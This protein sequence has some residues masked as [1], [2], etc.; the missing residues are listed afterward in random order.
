GNTPRTVVESVKGTANEVS[1]RYT[2]IKAGETIEIQCQT[3]GA[4]EGATDNLF[5]T[6]KFYTSGSFTGYPKC[7]SH[8][9]GTRTVYLYETNDFKIT[10][11]LQG[12]PDPSDEL[13]V[14][15]GTKHISTI[16]VTT[17][18][19]LTNQ[20]VFGDFDEFYRPRQ[21]TYLDGTYTTV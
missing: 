5:T 2:I 7:V 1:R 13:N 21:V 8:A 6:N 12:Q 16:G 10:T 14:L 9:D 4:L 11:I 18:Q 19:P 15:D 20:E 17:G 3:P